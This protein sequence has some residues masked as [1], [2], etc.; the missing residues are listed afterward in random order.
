LWEGDVEKVEEDVWDEGEMQR[1][2]TGLQL[3]GKD[4]SKIQ[5]FVESKPTGKIIGYYYLWKHSER[6]QAFK[7]KMGLAKF[8]RLT[9]ALNSNWGQDKSRKPFYD[10]VVDGGIDWDKLD[11]KR[12]LSPPSIIPPSPPLSSPSPS[13]VSPSPWPSPIPPFYSTKEQDVEE[14]HI[15]QGDIIYIATKKLKTAISERALS[16]DD[17]SPL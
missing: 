12:P 1:F 11:R 3:H 17:S 7:H 2:E 15:T 16:E 10:V 13:C 8:S 14:Q 5:K 4:F 6:Y 9:N